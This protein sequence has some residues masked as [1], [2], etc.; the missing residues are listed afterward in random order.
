MIRLGDLLVLKGELTSEQR[1]QILAAQADCARPFGA[2]AE[3]MFGISP[4]VVEHAW[5]QQH[6]L[7]APRVD[8]RRTGV[9]KEILGM[10]DRR[11]A[12]QFGVVPVRIENAELVLA[13]SPDLLVRAM[14]FAGWRVTMPCTFEMCDK[15]TLATALGIHYP[16]DGFD[17]AFIEQVMSG[18]SEAG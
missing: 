15:D 17:A 1:D 9:P 2:I 8:P 10:I 5:A 13:T 6:A 14:R 11:Q 16:I 18:L 12:W 4:Q 7:I 3:E